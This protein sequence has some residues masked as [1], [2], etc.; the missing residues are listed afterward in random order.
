MEDN[1]Q[2][3]S[4]SGFWYISLPEKYVIQ[5][6]NDPGNYVIYTDPSVELEDIDKKF[7]DMKDKTSIAE[8]MLNKIGVDT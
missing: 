7:D 8:E 1:N 3:F 6:E 4:V 5:M 2:W